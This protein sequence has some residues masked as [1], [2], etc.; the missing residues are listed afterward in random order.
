MGQLP[1]I[2][3]DICKCR[4]TSLAAETVR[5]EYQGGAQGGGPR[6][7]SALQVPVW[8]ELGLGDGGLESGAG[9]GKK[10]PETGMSDPDSAR[11]RGCNPPVNY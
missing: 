10:Q 7:S 2:V 11:T 5:Y 3:K 4:C 8:L 6:S 9:L 1:R